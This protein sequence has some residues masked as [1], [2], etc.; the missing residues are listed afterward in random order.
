[1]V[2]LDWVLLCCV[3]LYSHSTL[4]PFLILNKIAYN[5]LRKEN[6][7]SMAIAELSKKVKD[8]WSWRKLT[9][10]VRKNEFEHLASRRP[11]E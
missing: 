7:F 9:L 5:F 11:P 2:R 3:K 6:L 10:T 1:M 4:E 8:L